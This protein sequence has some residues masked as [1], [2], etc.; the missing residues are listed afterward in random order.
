[1]AHPDTRPISFTY[2]PVASVWVVS[3]HNLFLYSDLPLSC[4]PPAYWLPAIFKP[5][6]FPYKYPNISQIQSYFIPTSLWRC[7]RQC[8]ETS[9]YKIQMPGNYPEES[10]Q[11]TATFK[12]LLPP[13]LSTGSTLSF[14]PTWYLAFHYH[15]LCPR[16][17]LFSLKILCL[18]L[19][20]LL[21]NCQNGAFKYI[22][23]HSTSFMATE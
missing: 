18:C 11:V 21:A 22:M 6:L 4:H 16:I 15:N 1:M 12:I 5:N 7:N 9:A 3:L 23:F 19:L 2:L 14:H 10:L 17:V 8:S 20:P 13:Y